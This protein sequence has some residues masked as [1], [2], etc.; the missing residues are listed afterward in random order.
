MRFFIQEF[1]PKPVP[2][3]RSDS[4]QELKRSRRITGLPF[5]FDLKAYGFSTYAQGERFLE[6][7]RTL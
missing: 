2:P 6:E 7:K 1:L 5:D 4:S 3:E